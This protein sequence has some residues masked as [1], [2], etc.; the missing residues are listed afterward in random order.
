MSADERRLRALGAFARKQGGDLEQARI[1]LARAREELDRAEQA[2]R[3]AAGRVNEVEQVLRE[4]A[5]PDRPL[6]LDGM[7]LWQ[8]HLARQREQLRARWQ[9]RETLSER[10]RQAFDWLTR[11]ARS[12]EATERLSERTRSA[13]AGEGRRRGYREADELWLLGREEKP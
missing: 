10:T 5:D 8:S 3:A 13:L 4:R 6:S 12:L 9:A 1:G 11:C 2:L 7:R